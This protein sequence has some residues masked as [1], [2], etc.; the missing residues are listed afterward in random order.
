LQDVE[1]K[2]ILADKGYDTNDII[3]FATKAEMEIVISPKSNRKEQ[4]EYD[5]EVYKSRHLIENMFL[6][7]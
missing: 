5:K 2:K 4:R 1:A 6:L 7:V 3:E